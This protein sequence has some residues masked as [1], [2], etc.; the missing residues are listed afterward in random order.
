MS[1][2]VGYRFSVADERTRRERALRVEA[3]LLRRR[4]KG[5]NGRLAA[6]GERQ[7]QRQVA[8]VGMNAGEETLEALVASLNGALTDAQKAMDAAVDMQWRKRFGHHATAGT[9]RAATEQLAELRAQETKAADVAAQRARDAVQRAR[10]DA[11]QLVNESLGR[12]ESADL[13]GIS[14]LLDRV[15]SSVD[16]N[17]ARTATLHLAS[18][19]SDSLARRKAAEAT[20]ETRASLAALVQD[21]LAEDRERLDPLILNAA[22]PAVYADE[23]HRAVERADLAEHRAH[24][25]RTATAALRAAGC[26]IGADFEDLLAGSGEAVAPFADTRSGYGLLVRLPL[27]QPQLVAAVV[28]SAAHNATAD[29]DV[30]AQKDFCQRQLPSLVDSLHA[31]PLLRADQFLTLE[32]G[33]VPVGVIAPERWPRQA[34]HHTKHRPARPVTVEQERHLGHH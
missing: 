26:E 22:D 20:E 15:E 1:S 8:Q 33:R 27:E 31:D 29:H 9:A 14:R 21:A 32:P 25:V 12:C 17:A 10:M 28:R 3:A 30:Q 7:A 11:R 2:S 19:V 18:V 16:L 24:V 23:V 6:L 5:V 4:L 34:N 13:P